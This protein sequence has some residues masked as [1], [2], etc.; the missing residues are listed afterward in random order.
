MSL[1]DK[2][3]T[4]TYNFVSLIVKIILALIFSSTLL[5]LPAADKTQYFVYLSFNSTLQL[6]NEISS[7]LEKLIKY[8]NGA[9][10]VSFLVFY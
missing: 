9:A 3:T 2:V 6:I 8:F 1:A 10:I 7:N 4:G 5:S